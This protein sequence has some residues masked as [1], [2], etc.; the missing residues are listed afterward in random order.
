VATQLLAGILF[1]FGGIGGLT[2]ASY[3]VNLVLHNTAFIPG[4]FHLTVATAVTLSFMG[5]SYWLLP[6]LT[7]KK[8]WQPKWATIQAWTWFVG[9]IIFSNSMHVLGLLGAPRRV[10]LGLA[11][12]VP[13]EW[14]SRLFQVGLGVAILFLSGGIYLTIMLMTALNKEKVSEEVIVPI[15]ESMQDPANTPVWLDTWAPWIYGAL[16]LVVL[17]YGPVLFDMIKNIALTSPGFRVW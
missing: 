17:M 16:G 3:N 1:F 5:I 11:P 2:N 6:Y 12:Y 4:H 9:M 10:P 8:L 13:A 14:N 15:A 7:G